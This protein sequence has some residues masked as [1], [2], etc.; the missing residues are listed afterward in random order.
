MTL[1]MLLVQYTSLGDDTNDAVGPTNTDLFSGIGQWSVEGTTKGSNTDPCL[2][3]ISSG[4]ASAT[5]SPECVCDTSA[6]I[7]NICVTGHTTDNSWF[8]TEYAHSGCYGQYPYYYSSENAY[9]IYWNV[10]Y[11]RWLSYTL[12]GDNTNDA[13]GQ[14]MTYSQQTMTYS[15]VLVNGL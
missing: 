7:T 2:Q 12:L 11:N 1:M 14:T 5:I 9:Y 10:N 3:I 15:V 6:N 8:Y 4:C 13:V